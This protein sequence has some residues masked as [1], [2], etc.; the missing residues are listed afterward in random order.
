MRPLPL[1]SPMTQID[2][3]TAIIN[4]DGTI[5][6]FGGAGTSANQVQGVVAHDGVYIGNPLGLGA[7]ATN[8]VQTA[9]AVGDMTR[10]AANLNG[11]L[12]MC[13][14]SG[15]ADS[16]AYGM[17]FVVSLASRL[18]TSGSNLPLLVAGSWKNGS[19][20]DPITKPSLIS[21]LLSAAATTN[22]TLVRTGTGDVFKITGYNSNAAARYLKLYNK[23]TAPTVGTDTPVWTEYLPALSKFE[24]NM[25]TPLY[26]S[27]G[28]GYGLT[29]GGADADTGAL[30]AGDILALNVV[31]A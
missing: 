5:A 19:T 29:T 13:A 6:T 28:I 26:F 27:L 11:A 24:I 14:P 21:R 4:A 22:S 2:Y 25:P 30:I 7:Y 3:T 18:G 1:T 15:G 31:Y 16:A 8:A 20:W 10:V 17:Q 12:H 23:A 9:V